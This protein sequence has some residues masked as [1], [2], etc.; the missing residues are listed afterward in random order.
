MARRRRLAAALVTAFAVA[1]AMPAGAGAANLTLI[2]EWGGQGTAPGQFNLM[3]DLVVP[4]DGTVYTL[5]SGNDR[6]QHFDANGV[7]LGGWGSSGSGPGQ[8]SQPESMT[9]APSGD[10][11]IA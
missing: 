11:S 4:P 1:A 9:V 7:R 10:I 2:G 3:S 6:L 8:Y 5:E